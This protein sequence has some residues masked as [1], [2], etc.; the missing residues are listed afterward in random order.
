MEAP[1]TKCPLNNICEYRDSVEAYF[2]NE[3]T[4]RVLTAIAHRIKFA[5]N[6][7]DCKHYPDPRI[8]F[9]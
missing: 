7:T 3:E 6:V 8:N 1:C 4:Y 2:T 9:R 5:S